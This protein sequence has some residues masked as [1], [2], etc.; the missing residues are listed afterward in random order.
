SDAHHFAELRPVPLCRSRSAAPLK[1]ERRASA[2]IA[3]ASSLPISI[4]SSVEARRG[5]VAAARRWDSLPISIGSSVEAQ[6]PPESTA[7]IVRSLPISIGSSVEAMCRKR[8]KT[9]FPALSADLDRQ[10]R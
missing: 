7:K 2:R 1:H 4:G 6:D 9:P 3:G 10:L 8:Y 5:N